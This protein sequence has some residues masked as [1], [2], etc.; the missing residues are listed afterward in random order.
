MKEL[1]I[2]KFNPLK[3]E[4]IDL[5]EACKQTVI[6]IKDDKSIE[7]YTLMKENKSKLQKKRSYVVR[8]LKEARA[9]T[10]DYRDK[11][12]AFEKELVG[13]LAPLE[14][15]L[16]EKIKA[17][18]K[19]KE[20]IKRRELLPIRKESLAEIEFETTDEFLLTMDD[21]Q[22]ITF[23]TDEKF[24]YFE[25][26]EIALR[27]KQEK[28]AQKI[29]E[30]QDKLD[31]EKAKLAEDQRIKEASDKATK[32]AQDKA[33]KDAEEA[34]LK[35]ETDAAQA[36]KDAENAKEQAI[37]DEKQR[38]KAR[39]AKIVAD[40]KA[41]DDKRIAD[42]EAEKQ[43]IKDEE[44]RVEKEQ[45]GLEAKKAFQKFL[46]DFGYDKSETF[47]IE[48]TEKKVIL[49]KKIAEYEF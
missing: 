26:K 29:K 38:A 43:A 3:K 47:H 46:A 8:I 15:K 45:A 36:V 12:I 34:K 4:V 7:G 42:E 32:D 9:F 30:A 2:E 31:A 40:Q 16:S 25:K 18:D 48:K 10:L 6:A 20:I 39:E 44:E 19:E 49:Y 37:Q 5:V 23:L 22:F 14:D 33:I 21:A 24:N 11:N 13:I 1:N 28:E 41:I 17:I 27:E 35:A